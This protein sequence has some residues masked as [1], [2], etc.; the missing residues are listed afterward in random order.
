MKT[1]IRGQNFNYFDGYTFIAELY[2]FIV[3]FA[4]DSSSV[5]RLCSEIR[6]LKESLKQKELGNCLKDQF[7]ENRHFQ[8]M[9]FCCIWRIPD[10]Y[11]NLW[12]RQIE[13]VTISYTWRRYCSQWLFSTLIV[14]MKK[15]AV[16][17]S[18][19]PYSSVSKCSI[20]MSFLQEAL[21][22][23]IFVDLTLLYPSRA[24]WM[25]LSLNFPNIHN[26]PSKLTHLLIFYHVF[27][28]TKPLFHR[29]TNI[30]ALPD[31]CSQAQRHLRGFSRLLI[32]LASEEWKE[33]F[34][35]VSRQL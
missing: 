13:R 1:H 20:Y 14:S 11:F 7:S 9:E 8:V 23:K 10:L 15:W 35:T 29:S 24:A 6:L 27:V 34:S 19:C 26:C 31:Y 22:Q 33:C 25:R 16:W 28:V 17:A 12:S 18:C 2:R 4:D 32:V 3:A 30:S 21:L 5:E